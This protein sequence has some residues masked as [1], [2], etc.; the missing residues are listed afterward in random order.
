MTIV[1][2]LSTRDVKRWILVLVLASTFAWVPAS[3]QRGVL[4]PVPAQRVS[5]R[6]VVDLVTLVRRYGWSTS[7]AGT[8]LTIRTDTGI[9]TVFDGS[10]DALWQVAGSRD[11]ATV[12]LSTPPRSTPSAWWVP[13][14]LLQLLEI[15]TTESSVAV[16]GGFAPLAFPPQA[17]AGAGFEIAPLGSGMVGLRFYGAGPTGPDTISLMLSDLTLLALVVPAQ[18]ELLDRVL[19]E[20]PLATE[21]PLL[22]TVT[23]VASS[24][25][26]TSLVFE[27]GDLRFEAKHPFRFQLVSGSPDR[28]TP[29][30]PVV[31][32]VLLPAR[33]SLERPLTVNWQGVA[34]EV[35]FR[36]GR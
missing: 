3:A 4:E 22:V 10:P 17:Q 13:E 5:G 23:A 1:V 25:W 8:S 20:D 16:P 15:E 19:S 30:E 26:E 9:L 33:F 2:R 11:P 12:P 28:V 35:T 27:Q 31:G 29:A 34:G 14:D 32:V 6:V 24:T 21:H 7:D 18:R 36:P